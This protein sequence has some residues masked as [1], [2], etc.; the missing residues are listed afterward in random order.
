VH[1]LKQI[2]SREGFGEN[3]DA[4]YGFPVVQA[5]IVKQS[6]RHKHPHAGSFAA[7]ITGS[8]MASHVVHIRPNDQQF[9]IVFSQAID[10]SAQVGNR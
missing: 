6:T 8:I 7:E 2:S 9:R 4:M 5:V 1:L 10:S 3:F